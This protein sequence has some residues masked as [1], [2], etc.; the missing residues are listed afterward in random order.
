MF[1]FYIVVKK[2]LSCVISSKSPGVYSHLAIYLMFGYVL[3]YKAAAGNDVLLKKLP[4]SSSM[5]FLTA[6]S[7]MTLGC[8]ES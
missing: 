6:L 1:M 2:I 8:F 7:N 4:I 5:P 3:N